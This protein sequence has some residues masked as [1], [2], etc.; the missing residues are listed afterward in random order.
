[1]FVGNLVALQQTSIRRM[2]AFSSIAQAGY[3]LIA[4]A[5]ARARR[6]AGV[7]AVGGSLFHLMVNA[8]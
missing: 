4:V 1:M 2:L 6:T 8:G 3:L 7:Y 5:V